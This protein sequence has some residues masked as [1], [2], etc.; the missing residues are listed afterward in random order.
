[1]TEQSV[2]LVLRDFALTHGIDAT[3]RDLALTERIPELDLAMSPGAQERTQ[4][5]QD[6]PPTT[7]SH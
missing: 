1:M 6:A 4:A 2:S 7:A 3:P 5:P